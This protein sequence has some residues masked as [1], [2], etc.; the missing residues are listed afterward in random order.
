[1]K[2]KKIHSKSNAYLTSLLRILFS[3]SNLKQK[4]EASGYESH[5]I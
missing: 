3:E 5:I 2:V 4:K 1:M